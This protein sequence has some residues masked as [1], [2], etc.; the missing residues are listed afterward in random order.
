MFTQRSCI[1]CLK[2]GKY[3]ASIYSKEME[4]GEHQT[5]TSEHGGSIMSFHRL[6][7]Y[8][9]I[10]LLM[11]LLPHKPLLTSTFMRNISLFKLPSH[12]PQRFTLSEEVIVSSR[13]PHGSDLD[14]LLL[15][16]Y[17]NYNNIIYWN[18]LNNNDMENLQI[19]LKMLGKSA[20]ENK[21]VN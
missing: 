20:F 19:H 5:M 3:I 21:M 14:P 6:K 12:L 17:I 10:C 11:C 15:F 16:M 2:C 1:F 13:V 4:L 8:S 7:M 9:M 18:I